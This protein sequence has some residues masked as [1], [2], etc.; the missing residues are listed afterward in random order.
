[1]NRRWTMLNMSWKFSSKSS[2]SSFSL[3]KG[4]WLVLVDLRIP[5]KHAAGDR[6]D[7]HHAS[8]RVLPGWF[9]QRGEYSF[10]FGLVTRF[11]LQCSAG[12]Y[13][14]LHTLLQI[15]YYTLLWSDCNLLF[16]FS[17]TAPLIPPHSIA[18]QSL[19]CASLYPYNGNLRTDVWLHAWVLPCQDLCGHWICGFR[20][21]EGKK[22]RYKMC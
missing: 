20:Y 1:M 8:W 16:L 5:G 13:A 15:L 4:R 21:D 19:P 9:L 10:L 11:F 7:S 18:L 3:W 22:K 12:F 14:I 17:C 2:S 6:G